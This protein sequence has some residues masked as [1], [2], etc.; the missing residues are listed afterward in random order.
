ML[1]PAS[2]P[3]LDNLPHLLAAPMPPQL[4][5][6]MLHRP[7]ANGAR[8]VCALSYQ[9][10]LSPE[11]RFCDA[12]LACCR[13]SFGYLQAHKTRNTCE[14]ESHSKGWQLSTALD[15]GL[16][17]VWGRALAQHWQGVYSGVRCLRSIMPG[18]LNY[19]VKTW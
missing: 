17:G 16:A 19:R 4:R 5:Q 7:A 8:S 3:A 13:V 2:R 6:L 18:R 9:V 10:G 1:H 11:M 15:V 14:S 12:S